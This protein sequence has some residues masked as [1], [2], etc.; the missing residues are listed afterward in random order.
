MHI[1][2]ELNLYVDETDTS[3]VFSGDI[4]LFVIKK[5]IGENS[6]KINLSLVEAIQLRDFLN[7]CYPKP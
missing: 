6:A 4:N 1:D 2:K 7:Y 3:T 5:T